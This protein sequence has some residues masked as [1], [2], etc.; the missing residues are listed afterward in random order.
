MDHDH[1]KSKHTILHLAPLLACC[2]L[3][4]LAYSLFL[5]MPCPDTLPETEITTEDSPHTSTRTSWTGVNKSVTHPVEPPTRATLEK[6]SLDVLLE[7]MQYLEWHEL[8]K[9]RQVSSVLNV[10]TRERALWHACIRSSPSRFALRKHIKSCSSQ[11]LEDTFLRVQKVDRRWVNPEQG[12]P[13][14]VR[15]LDGLGWLHPHN[16]MMLPGGRWLLRLEDN[17]ELVY[18]DLSS[19]NLQWRTLVAPDPKFNRPW[20][21]PWSKIDHIVDINANAECLTFNVVITTPLHWNVD[22][23]PMPTRFDIWHCTPEFGERGDEVGLA[24]TLLSTFEELGITVH[25]ATV[26]LRGDF[27][28]C[29]FM[30]GSYRIIVTNWK[31][32]SGRGNSFPHFVFPRLRGELKVFGYIPVLSSAQW[33]HLYLPK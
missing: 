1:L 21:L 32:A 4:W 17:T 29:G 24:A 27:I 13:P 8:L 22:V 12:P 14:H 25:K 26:A 19:V 31:E 28:A 16:C 3:G 5:S 20:V 33:A 11:E 7:I 30:Y 9:L 18:A 23:G 10:A 15:Q 6:V 2:S